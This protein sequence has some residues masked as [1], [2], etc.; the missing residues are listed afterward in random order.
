MADLTLPTILIVDDDIASCRLLEALLLPEGYRTVTALGGA[1]AL[2]AI[3]EYPPDLILL[4]VVMPQLNGCEVAAILKENPATAAIPIIMVTARRDRANR[5]AALNAGAEEILT[6]PV[7]RIELWLRVRNL[8]R[9]KAFTDFLQ[10]HRNILEHQIRLRAVDLQRFRSAMDA[11]ADAILL[12]D[13]ATRRFIEVNATASRMSGYTPEEL[14]DIG[15]VGLAATTIGQLDLVYDNIVE[16]RGGSVTAEGNLRRKDGTI[17]PVEVQRHA[18]RSGADW[19][20]VS[21]VR[22]ISE[23]KQAEQR[24]HLL[25]HYDAL[26]GLPNRTL[27]DDTLRKALSNNIDRMVAVLCV[28]LDQLKNINDTLGRASGDELLRQFSNRLVRTGYGRE[29]LGRIGG[30]EFG[31]IIPI[32]HDMDAP[33]LTADKVREQLRAPFEL[34]DQTVM[35]T[36][37]IGISMYPDDAADPEA[38]M[39]YAETAMQHAKQAGCD[40]VRFFTAEMNARILDRLEMESALRTAIERDEFVLHYQPKVALSSDR[41]VGVEA[42]LRWQRPGYGLVLPSDF[43]PILEETGMIVQV[44]RWVIHAACRQIAQWLE[45]GTGPM[46][47]SVNISGRQFIEGDLEADVTEALR[48]N[49][50]APALLELELTEGSLMANTERTMGIMH[51]LKAKGVQISIDDFGTGYSSLSYLRRF[52]ID[53]LKIDIAFIR[54][55]TTNQEDAAIAVMLIRMAHSLKLIVVAEG[56]ENVAQ[57]HYLRIHHCDQIQGY[58]FS[59]PLPALALERLLA[60]SATASRA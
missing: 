31:L 43:I 20:I 22:D 45:N 21:V 37:S 23:R 19:I 40:T 33:A 8:L 6:K 47:V 4:D 1:A 38:L 39:N 35:I 46:Q 42:L 59:K 2:K 7:E 17:L 9:L 54:E 53:K 27:F 44:G 51:S 48:G 26:T 16:K 41:I 60:Q 56:V 24:L 10:S 13:R 29:T 32:T 58:L 34:D 57:A 18:H 3:A 49:A 52:P 28:D 36:A 11:S 30:D 25:A 15:P 12:I 5:L 50:I 14:M 55:I